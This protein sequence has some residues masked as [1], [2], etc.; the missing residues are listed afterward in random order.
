MGNAPNTPNNPNT[1]EQDVKTVYSSHHQG[2][3]G[4][5]ELNR[6][7]L[8]PCFEK[9]E[10]T[11]LILDAVRAAALGPVVAPDDAGEAPL[12]AVHEHHYLDFLKTAWTR[13]R[14]EGREGCAL[15]FCLAARGMRRDVIPRGIDGLLGHYAI[16]VG[17][18][19]VEGTWRA[20]YWAAQ[21]AVTGA[22]LLAGEDYAFALCRPPGHHAGP[23]LYGGYSFL[24]NAAIAAEDLRRQGHARVAVL[25]VDYH[26]GNGTQDIFW[27]RGDVLYA[28]LHADPTTDFPYFKGYADE[29]GE[30][31]GA[32]ATVNLPL[33]RGTGWD[34]Y[35]PALNR[36]LD[37]VQAFAPGALVVSL[38]VDTW[39]GDPISGFTLETHHFAQIGRA[40]GT[41]GLPTLFVFEGGYAVE[42]VGANVTQV[43]RGF[44]AGR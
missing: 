28:S 14:A 5:L 4:G 9:P 32:G 8:V 21:T 6:G 7:A 2:H 37:R 36:L 42:P 18:P 10:R 12:L 35:G 11:E 34:T 41:L 15:P 44:K 33:P 29:T 30:G 22:R 3:A 19:I 38:G 20:A 43:L 39:S 17:T 31:A 26:H 13:W 27:D 40:I 25:D 24:N 23:S 16:D 1:K